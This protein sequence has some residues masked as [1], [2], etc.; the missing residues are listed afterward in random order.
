M[1]E[2]AESTNGELNG[3][4]YGKNLPTKQSATKRRWKESPMEIVPAMEY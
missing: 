1:S 2:E 3:A 4:T